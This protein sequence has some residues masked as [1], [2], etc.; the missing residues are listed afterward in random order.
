M[1]K[2]KIKDAILDATGRPQVGWVVEN[3]DYLAQKIAEALG[4][5]DAPKPAIAIPT[6]ATEPTAKPSS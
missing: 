2:Q 4:L 6:S 1:S 3:A 5:A